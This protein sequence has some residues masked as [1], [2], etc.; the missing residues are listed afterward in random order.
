M[1]TYTDPTRIH[2][3]DP[4]HIEGNMVFTYLEFFGE[5]ERV[6]ELKNLYKEGKVADVEVKNY[7]LESLMKTFKD[8]RTRYDELKSNPQI[9]KKILQDGAEKARSVAAKTMLEVKEMIGIT[10]RYSFFKYL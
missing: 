1:S 8:A 3:T 6:E 10:N 7:L 4:G 5:K 2:P 9:V